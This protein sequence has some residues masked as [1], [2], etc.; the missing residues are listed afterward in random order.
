MRKNRY[1]PRNVFDAIGTTF[2]VIRSVSKSVQTVVHVPVEDSAA[3]AAAISSRDTP[4]CGYLETGQNI[5]I[6]NLVF[7]LPISLPVFLNTCVV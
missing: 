3:T 7:R 1:H 5:G 2:V 6:L 4:A